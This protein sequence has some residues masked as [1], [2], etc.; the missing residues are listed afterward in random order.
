MLSETAIMFGL[1]LDGMPSLGNKV[2]GYGNNGEKEQ[3]EQVP[4]SET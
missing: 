4:N 3:E 1:K 2:G